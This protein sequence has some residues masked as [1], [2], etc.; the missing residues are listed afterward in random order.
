M[1]LSLWNL[2]DRM[3]FSMLSGRRT[4]GNPSLMSRDRSREGEKTDAI[5][6]HEVAD[7]DFSPSIISTSPAGSSPSAFPWSR[8]V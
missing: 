5:E 6:R 7:T 1:H 2:Y 8:L 4:V 3:A